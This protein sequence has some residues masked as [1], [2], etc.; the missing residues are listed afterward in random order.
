MVLPMLLI[1]AAAAAQAPRVRSR[2]ISIRVREHDEGSGR[3]FISPMGEPFYGRT[4]GEDGLAVWFAQADRNH[5]G[6][7]TV[8]E[9]TGGRRP[10]FPGARSHPRRRDRPRRHRLLR[11]HGPRQS[12]GPYDGV[13]DVPTTPGGGQ[14]SRNISHSDEQGAGALGPARYPGAG[15]FSRQQL[16]SRRFR[17]GIPGCRGAALPIARHQSPWQA[18]AAAARGHSS[19]CIDLAKRRPVKPGSSDCRAT[20][21]RP[22][23]A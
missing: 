10:V 3:L 7:I 18:H 23:A 5:D 12:P 6:M 17:S 21:I 13:E 4:V 15:R 9:M 19:R 8:D 1:A 16:Q 11:A 20:R 2:P 22:A 14:P